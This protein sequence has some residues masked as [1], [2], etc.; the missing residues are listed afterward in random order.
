MK[1]KSSMGILYLKMG[2][3]KNFALAID[4]T[5]MQKMRMKARIQYASNFT[6]LILLN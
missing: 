3:R 4:I 2:K 6:T 5:Q 1:S